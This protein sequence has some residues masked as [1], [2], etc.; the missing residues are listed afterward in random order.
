MDEMLKMKDLLADESDKLSRSERK[1]EELISILSEYAISNG[2]KGPDN[3][4][5]AGKI[6]DVYVIL[7]HELY[8]GT[9]RLALFVDGADGKREE[10]LRVSYRHG[11]YG[12]RF[13]YMVENY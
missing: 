8:E 10:V 13:D 12:N 5:D 2:K 1:L 11:G 4:Y 7:Y 6:L 3:V 9:D